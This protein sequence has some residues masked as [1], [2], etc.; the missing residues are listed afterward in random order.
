MNILVYLFGRKSLTADWKP[1]PNLQLTV[2]LGSGLFCGLPLGIP[3]VQLAHLGP[4]SHTQVR[5][6]E[7]ALIYRHYGFH[8]FLDEAQCLET[9]DINILAEDDMA[10]FT[11]KWCLQGRLVTIDTNNTPEQIKAILGVPNKVEGDKN[12]F[13][14]CD[15][16]GIWFEWGESGQLENVLLSALPM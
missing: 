2:D 6:R 13:Y 9:V 15:K 1:D 8:V 14:T 11:G 3:I 12:L 10:A 7:D 4:S 16:S 5:G